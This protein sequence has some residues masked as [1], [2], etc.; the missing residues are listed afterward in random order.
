MLQ[1]TTL[2]N[3]LIYFVNRKFIC[4]NSII[5]EIDHNTITKFQ[6]WVLPYLLINNDPNIDEIENDYKTLAV[7]SLKNNVRG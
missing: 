2:L 7:R 5:C 1:C 4:L 6:N 3:C